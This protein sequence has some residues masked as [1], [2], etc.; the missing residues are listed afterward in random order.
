MASSDDIRRRVI[1]LVGELKPR[2]PAAGTTVTVTGDGNIVG[3]GN[4]V[5]HTTK[6]TQRTKAEPKPGTEHIDEDQ[7]FRIKQL[8]DE[9]VRLEATLKRDPATFQA[10][11]KALNN[12][13]RVGAMRMIPRASFPVAENFLRQWIGRL[14]NARSAPKKDSD[15]RRRRIAYIKTNE[16]K[17]GLELDVRRYLTEKFEVTS[18]TELDDA[19]LQQVYQFVSG[20]KRRSD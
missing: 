4:V 17:L 6:L 12:R 5:V 19:Q 1:D 18:L 2:A 20:L 16:R 10:V 11:Y 8:V 13:C 3:D 7:V 9:I 14:S 15:W